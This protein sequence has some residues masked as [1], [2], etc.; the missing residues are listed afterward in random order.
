MQKNIFRINSFAMAFSAA[1]MEFFTSTS[2]ISSDK[3]PKRED[4][5]CGKTHD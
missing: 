2:I 5:V 3:K 1:E 4:Q